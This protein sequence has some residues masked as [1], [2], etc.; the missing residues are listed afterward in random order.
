MKSQKFSL[1]NRLKSFSYAFNGLKIL[2]KEE[3]NARIHFIATIG[4]ITLSVI[5]QISVYEWIAIIFAIGFVFAMEIVNTAI[6]NMADFLSADMDERIMRIKDL[7]AAATLVSVIIALIT[8]LI[9]F[10]PKIIESVRV[11]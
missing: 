9:I 3:H 6:E 10:L 1:K 5:F 8:G 11:N 4:A 7:A 2:F